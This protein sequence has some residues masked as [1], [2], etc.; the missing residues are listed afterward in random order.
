MDQAAEQAWGRRFG[1]DAD[2]GRLV[3]PLDGAT[4]LTLE[5]FRAWRRRAAAT[6]TE[7][8]AAALTDGGLDEVWV[9][10]AMLVQAAALNDLRLLRQ[11]EYL[12]LRL[13]ALS[14]SGHDRADIAGCLNDLGVTA[15]RNGDLD[16]ALDRYHTGLRLARLPFESSDESLRRE[17]AAIE[18]LT[19]VNMHALADRNGLRL[20]RGLPPLADVYHRVRTAW[21]DVAAA[22]LAWQVVILD[23]L[24]QHA[25]AARLARKLPHPCFMQDSLSLLVVTRARSCVL[26]RARQV[27]AALRLWRC[28]RGRA[29]E[30]EQD[31]ADLL[32]GDLLARAGRHEEAYRLGLQRA[33]R[34]LVPSE[35]LAPDAERA[36]AAFATSIRTL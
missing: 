17:L 24:G 11:S 27:D 28:A 21:P 32:V 23:D 7:T 18:G 16:T 26:V 33:E 2:L 8:V 6:A 15:E 30:D 20:P 13:L 35:P 22:V 31:D 34:S 19:M 12:Q 3:D 36:L 9:P 5:G 1:A 4:R 14:E 10:R 29:A 25:E